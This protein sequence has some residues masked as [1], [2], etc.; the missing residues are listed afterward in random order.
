MRRPAPDAPPLRGAQF[1]AA[2]NGCS[3]DAGVDGLTKLGARAAVDG[4]FWHTRMA[5][6][7]GR[8]SG[9]LLDSVGVGQAPLNS[10]LE[11][12]FQLSFAAAAGLADAVANRAGAA[13]DWSRLAPLR[14]GDGVGPRAEVE[15]RVCRFDAR[16][17]VVRAERER[18]ILAWGIC[19]EVFDLQAAE[20]VRA[21][22]ATR[23]R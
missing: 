18:F 9:V 8:V 21:S 14:G 7:P 15:H 12:E 11:F 5:D 16:G 4:Y 19:G 3:A 20:G 13:S 2:A 6:A 1:D 23:R 22:S 17:D 10:K